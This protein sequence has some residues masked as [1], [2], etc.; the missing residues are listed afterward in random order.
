MKIAEIQRFCMHDGPGVRT[1]IFLKGCPLRCAWCHNPETQSPHPQLLFEE[2]KCLACR[3]CGE[4]PQEVHRFEKMHTL[5]RE[6]CVACGSC[7]SLCPTG[8]LSLCGKDMTPAELLE[9]ILRDAPFYQNGGGVTLS[10]GEPFL[11]GEEAPEL[12]R[13]CKEK[14]ISTA[15]ETC[16]YVS[17]AL[18]EKAVPFVDLFLWDVKDTDD[19]RHLAYTGVSNKPIMENLRRVDSL[20]GKTRLRCILVNGVN[21]EEAH[22]TAIAELFHSLQNCE[23]VELLPYHPYG[24]SKAKAAGMASASHREWIPSEET[25]LQ[26]KNALLSQGVPIHG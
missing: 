15:V 2:Q 23:G 1:V 17:P 18:L 7:V 22:Y 21:T 5:Q 19:P 26:G 20:G 4:C 12:L 24:D 3:A 8:A 11:Q 16:G 25:V 13:L 6:S 9:I 10:G 14:G